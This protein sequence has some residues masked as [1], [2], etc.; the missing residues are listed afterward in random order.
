MDQLPRFA[1]E[2]RAHIPGRSG[3]RSALVE[4]EP[5]REPS[6]RP[7]VLCRSVRG[8]LV[9]CPIRPRLASPAGANRRHR[10]LHHIGS[11][12][13]CSNDRTR[14][15][16]HCDGQNDFGGVFYHRFRDGVGT[17]RI[18]CQLQSLAAGVCCH[19][20]RRALVHAGLD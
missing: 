7:V 17:G 10:T 4:D 19:H 12:C 2:W 9:V 5:A 1:R 15:Q 16:R 18:V 8:C 14:F 11:G 20:V 13:L 3:N 6:H